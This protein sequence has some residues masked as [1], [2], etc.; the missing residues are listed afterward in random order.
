M[1]TILLLLCYNKAKDV[2]WKGADVLIHM[3]SNNGMLRNSELQNTHDEYHQTLAE[4]HTDLVEIGR[5]LSSPHALSNIETV[6]HTL[7]EQVKLMMPSEAFFVARYH[8]STDKLVID[9]LVDNGVLDPWNYTPVSNWLRKLL[10]E[11]KSSLLFSTHEEFVAFLRTI[12]SEA[13]Q[14]PVENTPG[15]LLCQ[16]LLFVPV[17]YGE[18]KIGVLSVQSYNSYAYSQRHIKVLKEIGVQAGLAITNARLYA[19]LRAAL[20]QAQESERLKNYFLMTASH[21]LRTPLTAI[22]GYLELLHNFSAELDASVK[23]RFIAKAQRACEELVLMLGNVMDTSR[24]D[25]EH[26]T[27][28]YS[29]VSVLRAVSLILE[30]MEPTVVREKRPVEIMV[31]KD[32]SIWGDDLRLRQILLNLVSNALKYTPPSTKVAISAERVT[33]EQLSTP[34]FSSLSTRTTLLSERFVIIRVRDWGRG[35]AP[36]DQQHLF[37]RFMRLPDAVQSGQRGS[38]LGLYLCRQL[39]EAMGGCIGVESDGLAGEGSTFLIALPESTE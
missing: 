2:C 5:A 21:E 4:E 33:K 10:L 31:D 9:Y 3:N 25:Q 24:V 12:N 23:Q 20:Q 13:A 26:I 28:K 34:V 16:S 1:I 11:E 14:E 38:G 7:Y 39:T 18:E 29:T 37:S 19:D 35:I 36:E 8:Q 32:V 27:L 6:Y 15:K 22:Q 30:I 17:H